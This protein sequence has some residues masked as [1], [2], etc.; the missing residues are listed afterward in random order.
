MMMGLLG[1]YS[2]MA[3]YLSGFRH[4]DHEERDV[5]DLEALNVDVHA[6]RAGTTI[7]ISQNE[8]LEYM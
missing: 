8:C 6:K 5:R 7:D 1:P 4:D 3:R 2:L